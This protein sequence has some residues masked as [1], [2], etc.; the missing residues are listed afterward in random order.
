MMRFRM[1]ACL[2]TVLVLGS[3]LAITS[4]ASA[5]TEEGVHVVR[6]SASGFEQAHAVAF[7]PDGELIAVGGTSGIYFID[8]QNLSIQKF[9]RTNTS[10]RSV[11]F[12]PNSNAIAAGLFDNTIKTWDILSLQPTRSIDGHLGWVRSIAFS[13][14]GALIAS[15]SDD[16]TIRVWQAD[17]GSPVLAL[18]ADTTGVRAV[19]LSPDGTLV[20]GALGDKTVRVWSVPSGQLL[21]TLTGHEDWVRCLSFSPDGQVLASGAFDK[22]IYLW[23]MSNGKRV[24]K[25][26][27]HASSV[28][29]VAFSPDGRT[30]ASGSVD[31]TVRLWDVNTGSPLR[32]LQGHTD[33]VY[34]VAFSPNGQTLVSGS[35]DNTIRLWNMEV[36]GKA[37]PQ[38]EFPTV[39]TSSDCRACHHRRGQLE[40]ARVIELNCESCHEGGISFAWCNGFP[41]SDQVQDT[42]IAFQAVPDVSGVPVNDRDLA[43]MIASPG[44]G[45]TLYVRGRFMAPEFISGKVFYADPQSL[46]NLQIRLDIISGGEVTAS[47]FTRPT[48]KGTFNFNVAIN[49]SSPPPHLSRPGTRQCLV[50]HGDFI[51]EAGLPKGDVHLVVTA[52]GP[53]GQQATD[54]R[55]IHVDPSDVTSIPIQVLDAD[56]QN[57]L[58]GLSIEATGVL[59][60]WRSHFA[61]TT[62]D[63][64]GKAQFDLESLTQANTTYTLSIPPQVSNGILYSSPTPVE[65]TLNPGSSLHAAQTL[66]ARA[67]TGQL[68]GE[69]HSAGLTSSLQ[70]TD[71]WAIQLPF[72]PAYQAVLAS[73]NTFVFNGIPVSQYL[74]A[75]DREL[76]SKQGLYAS[77][78]NV[79]LFE[80]PVTNLSFSLENVPVLSGRVTTSGGIPLPFGWVRAGNADVTQSIDPVTG[81]FLLPAQG[82]AAFVAVSAPGYYSRPQRLDRSTGKLEV[83]LVPRP[84]LRLIP[85]GDGQV[86]FPPETRATANELNFDLESGWLWGQSNAADPV[87]IHLPGIRVAIQKGQFALEKPV[88]GTG[89]LYITQGQAEIYY[90]GKISPVVVESGKMIA[91]ENGAQ[92]FSIE[93]SVTAALHP[94]LKEIPILEVIEP[95]LTAQVQSWLIH[96]SIGT[97]QIITFITYILSLVTIITIPLIVLFSYQKKR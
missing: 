11:A 31:E 83:Q 12:V 64:D 10:A 61:T 60:Q 79:D 87:E 36:F 39:T 75:P 2:L 23:D 5:Q 40:P 14:D 97:L 76:L 84:E 49:S 67:V 22:N 29:G 86:F 70:N 8:V 90:D 93:S 89:W 85:W 13:A 92:P 44:N 43:V 95:S 24:Q 59:Y 33:F 21:Y 1:F 48:E 77:P 88:A 72:G 55:W 73:Q 54:D 91:L 52:I 69:I 32:V 47:L 37:Q 65:L 25:L 30:L 16:D 26:E 63:A 62:T 20:A 71:V 19:A 56:T 35:G 78:Y 4:H 3:I 51:P 28:L 38:S 66:T 7:S 41:R 96:T 42:P 58:Q 46:T 68:R 17:N 80:T 74:V 50:C 9:I 45:E 18:E 6:L 34:A 81:E 82:D 15:A 53:N 94:T 57:P 27:G